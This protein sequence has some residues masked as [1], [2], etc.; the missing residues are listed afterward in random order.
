MHDNKTVEG[1]WFSPQ[2]SRLWS[3]QADLGTTFARCTVA[4]DGPLEVPRLNAALQRLLERHSIL[5]TSFCSVPGVP[6]P[7]QVIAE[8][9]TLSSEESQP[10][11]AEAD[12]P[13]LA[14]LPALVTQAN[15]DLEQ[16]P[17][18]KCALL[19]C[20][21][22]IT[23]CSSLLPTLCADTRSLQNLVSD[24]AQLY[25][26]NDGQVMTEPALSYVQFSEWQN[27]LLAD[28]EHGASNRKHWQV[29]DLKA[30]RVCAFAKLPDRCGAGN[31]YAGARNGE[32]HS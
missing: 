7:L 6:V 22:N 16:A 23:C 1:Y 26:A 2:Q 28:H 11:P 5:R 8:D 25:E 14:Q 4:I 27:E 32:L 12:I 20:S 13:A 10:L 31:I 3:I 18:L 21:R 9:L 17:L 24:L 30:S 15:Q 29:Q 19:T